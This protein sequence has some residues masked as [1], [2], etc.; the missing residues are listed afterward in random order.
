MFNLLR[1]LFKRD[2]SPRCP[3]CG[4]RALGIHMTLF[5][6]CP[7]L[8]IHSEC[9]SCGWS[10]AGSFAE[11]KRHLTREGDPYGLLHKPN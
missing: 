7:V 6:N 8:D 1:K 10:D 5:T 3:R 2:D 9:K 11:W 4:R